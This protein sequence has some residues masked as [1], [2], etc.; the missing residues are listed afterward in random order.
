MD[1]DPKTGGSNKTMMMLIVGVVIGIV[2]GFL[3]GYLL[4]FREEL[5]TP[6]TYLDAVKVG[7]LPDKTD[8]YRYSQSQVGESKFETEGTWEYANHYSTEA[9]EVPTAE[10]ETVDSPCGY[11]AMYVGNDYISVSCKSDTSTGLERCDEIML[12]MDLNTKIKES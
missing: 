5:E 1:Q 4:L 12:E 6:V 10:S 9:C 3:L 11:G 2:L 7:T 8:I